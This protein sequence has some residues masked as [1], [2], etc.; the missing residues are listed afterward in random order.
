[1]RL[2][3][4]VMTAVVAVMLAAGCAG[5]PGLRAG[6]RIVFLGDSITRRGTVEKGFVTLT[7]Q[8]I[9]AARPGEGIEVI[10]A[11]VG[12]NRVSD[13]QKRLDAD[14]L[15]KEPTIVVI[16]IG[17]NDVWLWD[18]SKGKV[19]PAYESGLRDL[20]TRI[21]AKGARVLLATPA[22]S[23]E[24][25]DGT[26]EKEAILEDFVAVSRRVAREE[27]V[28]LIDLRKIFVEYLKR[29]NRENVEKGLLTTDGVHMTELGNR[30]LAE[31]MLEALGVS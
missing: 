15:A 14:V 2:N 19:D 10:G 31:A 27:G 26:N 3:L 17:I 29:H 23:G 9:E 25:T 21:E 30:L 20:I 4:A 8:A 18:P 22:S 6:D 11:G 7:R 13:L 24:K 16:I 28:Q 12:S 1:M 5:R